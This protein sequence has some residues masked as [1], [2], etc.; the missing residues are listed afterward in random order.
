MQT[1]EIPYG[2]R[3]QPCLSLRQDQ[4]TSRP[5]GV[6]VSAPTNPGVQD[7]VVRP[8]VGFC[9]VADTL[10]RLTSGDFPVV[11]CIEPRESQAFAD[12]DAT[13]V[14][15]TFVA[16]HVRVAAVTDIEADSLSLACRM[17]PLPFQAGIQLWFYPARARE[18]RL[19]RIVEATI[20]RLLL[21]KQPIPSPTLP[22]R[23]RVGANRR[24]AMAG[25]L[26]AAVLASNIGRI[27]D[28]L[29][30]GSSVQEGKGHCRPAHVRGSC[31]GSPLHIAAVRGDLAV[32][33]VLV[34]AGANPTSADCLDATPLHLAA[35]FG[36]ADVARFL[37]RDRRVSPDA[38]DSYEVT[39][40]QQ[41]VLR[42]H[43]DVVAALLEHPLTDPNRN[44]CAR[45]RN[46][47]PLFAAISRSSLAIVQLLLADPRIDTGVSWTAGTSA[48]LRVAQDVG[49]AD[50]IA[51]VSAHDERVLR[52]PPPALRPRRALLVSVDSCEIMYI[53]MTALNSVIMVQEAARAKSP[54]AVIA[55]L[56]DHP[57]DAAV[58]IMGIHEL[59][60]IIFDDHQDAA[61]RCAAA[62][63]GAVAAATAALRN[64][65]RAPSLSYSACTIISA[66]ADLTRGHGGLPIAVEA[67]APAALVAVL[68]ASLAPPLDEQALRACCNTLAVVAHTP[69]GLDAILAA[70]GVA[71]A[72]V[73]AIHV[74]PHH[75]E[76]AHAACFLLGRMATL[77]SGLVAAVDAGA[78][79]AVVACL[80]ELQDTP[81]VAAQASWLLWTMAT[82]SPAGRDAATSAG[83]VAAL[84]AALSEHSA[85]AS[86]VDNASGALRA[87][88]A[89]A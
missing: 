68:T 86:V 45:H 24:R 41:A 79:A 40:L 2:P 33:R 46:S 28:A 12:P 22:A 87:L 42:G 36:H 71:A 78:P 11:F 84:T 17:A 13:T 31:G 62:S 34:G 1:I 26:T 37:L 4:G 57:H 6:R 64:H 43:T 44:V 47:S 7:V 5:I 35:I 3:E 72:L 89:I 55:V 59:V 8:P 56:A 9:D 76:V 29:W 80:R 51:L 23:V 53:S 60:E 85:E 18:A 70:G 32:V 65:G 88:G 73:D 67:G 63:A 66:L 15:N 27:V 20:P 61:S 52:S 19:G 39:P 75:D 30:S 14:F 54:A 69:S 38:L 74:L 49:R 77:P 58:V 10:P 25:E 81:R 50:I 83:A 48:A 16:R 82:A 21:D